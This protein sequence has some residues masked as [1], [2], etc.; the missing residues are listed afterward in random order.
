MEYKN[1]QPILGLWA[2]TVPQGKEK[3]DAQED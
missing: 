3:G 2:G 1:N